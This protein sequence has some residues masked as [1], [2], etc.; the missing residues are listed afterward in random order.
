MNTFIENLC[1]CLFYACTKLKYHLLSS[2]CIVTC[3][4]D[5]IKCMLY[6]PIMS[7]RIGKWAYAL[8]KYNLFYESLK[9][10]KGQILV[11][12]IVEYWINDSCELYVFFITVTPC[13]LYFEG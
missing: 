8:I 2:S 3:Q 4:A 11:D 13:T 9:S 1:L 10:I 6:N 5:M 12:F 7:G